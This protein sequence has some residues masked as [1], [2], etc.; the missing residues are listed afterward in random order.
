[1]G[2]AAVNN[3]FGSVQTALKPIQRYYA[4]RDWPKYSALYWNKWTILL[5]V[6]VILLAGGLVL[7]MRRERNRKRKLA[8]QQDFDEMV[9]RCG[10]TAEDLKYFLPIVNRASLSRTSAIFTMPKAFE[11][12]AARVMEEAFAS[13][14]SS[15]QRKTLILRI[16]SIR[17][18]LGF[19]DK[20]TLFPVRRATGKGLSS[21]QIPVGKTVRVRLASRPLDTP[22]DAEVVDNNEFEFVIVPDS[23]LP[24]LS[25]QKWSIS[26]PSGSSMWEFDS[27]VVSIEPGKVAFSHSQQVRFVNRRRFLRVPV[28]KTALIS[29][30]PG[31]TPHIEEHRLS[32]APKFYKAKITELSGPGLRLRTRLEVKNG[33]RILV[34]FEME[35]GK[36]IQDIAY[37]RGIK[38]E[39]EHYTLGIELVGIDDKVVDQLVRATN[40][41]AIGMTMTDPARMHA[42]EFIPSQNNTADAQAYGR[43]QSNKE[44]I[45]R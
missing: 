35:P 21:R 14:V 38:K 43:T 7:V 22:I 4:M 29:P 27:I 15:Q 37:V 18:K 36:I 34:I 45:A 11:A 44:V 31:L 3:L 17:R 10:L 30:F 26:Y 19:K 41:A 25:G 20:S 9:H 39:D 12:G 33:Q 1:M 23:P 6:S 32:M 8:D 40:T 42:Q 13:Q 24:A 28:E 2:M 16:N 5:L